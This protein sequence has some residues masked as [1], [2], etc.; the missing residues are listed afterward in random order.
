VERQTKTGGRSCAQAGYVLSCSI[1]TAN[2]TASHRTAPHRT[3]S[4]RTA[5]KMMRVAFGKH[6]AVKRPSLRSLPFKTQQ[7]VSSQR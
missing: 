6:V 5:Q 1:A 2:R 3:A 7:N 4:H